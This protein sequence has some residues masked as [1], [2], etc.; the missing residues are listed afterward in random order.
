MWTNTNMRMDCHSYKVTSR[1]IFLLLTSDGV[2]QMQMK[3]KL[4]LYTGSLLLNVHIIGNTNIQ[5]YQDLCVYMNAMSGLV[6]RSLKLPP[7]V[8]LLQM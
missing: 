6:D 3:I 7:S 1:K 8:I 2:Q 4:S 5:K